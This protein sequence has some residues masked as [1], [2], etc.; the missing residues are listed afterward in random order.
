MSGP[1]YENKNSMAYLSYP[2]PVPG[3]E[4]PL[5]EKKELR[6]TF[7]RALNLPPKANIKTLKALYETSKG[8][9]FEQMTVE[10]YNEEGKPYRNSR[11][12]SHEILSFITGEKKGKTAPTFEEVRN[13]FS[14]MPQLHATRLQANKEKE[15]KETK[16]FMN[17]LQE[18]SKSI[19][20]GK[21]RKTRR[22][23]KNKKRTVR[24][25]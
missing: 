21:R 8:D 23:R 5:R 19:T 18:A 25:R 16:S 24:R 22:A 13:V 9:P 6:K 15:E 3:L 20:G 10:R 2:T 11:I 7:R 4:A 12:P 1:V 14:S 17:Y